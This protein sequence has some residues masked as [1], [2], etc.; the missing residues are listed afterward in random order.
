MD[1]TKKC[2]C[3]DTLFDEIAKTT[4][5]EMIRAST[6]WTQD[7]C[8]GFLDLSKISILHPLDIMELN[9]AMRYLQPRER[10]RLV[11]FVSNNHDKRLGII[12][13]RGY[14]E[15]ET[16]LDTTEPS[17]WKRGEPRL[18][19]YDEDTL[20][21]VTRKTSRDTFFF[22]V[23]PESNLGKITC[24]NPQSQPVFDFTAWIDELT[25]LGKY[26]IRRIWCYFNWNR[27]QFFRRSGH[28][29]QRTATTRGN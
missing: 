11:A 23:I 25:R 6:T 17:S 7:C 27:P 10:F 4:K 28:R 13:D 22:N 8:V 16:C 5:L 1:P 12:H 19:L 21:D 20:A 2:M 15:S 18:C 26:R 29:L 3:C 14:T 24:R 9:H